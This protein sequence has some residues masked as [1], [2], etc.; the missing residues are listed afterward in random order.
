MQVE[1]LRLF[2]L[3]YSPSP[4]PA[5]PEKPKAISTARLSPSL[6]ENEYVNCKNYSVKMSELCEKYIRYKRGGNSR[7]RQRIEFG[8]VLADSSPKTFSPVES[9]TRWAISPRVGALKLTLTDFAP[10]LTLL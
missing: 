2:W 5:T 3:S 4:S 8:K 1:R 6:P 9:I 7:E 10:L